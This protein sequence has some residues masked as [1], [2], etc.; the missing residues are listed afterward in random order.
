[1]FHSVIS[2][3]DDRTAGKPYQHALQGDVM[4]TAKCLRY[5]AG[6]ADK[7]HGDVIESG[8]EK[9]VYTIREPVGVCG[10]IIPYVS[11]TH[12]HYTIHMT[13]TNT[14]WNFPLVSARR[15]IEK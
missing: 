14:R 9:L 1:M 11:P 2:S 8:S 15:G 4:G 10:Q 7:M 3:S 6:W 13:Y 12:H 5:Y